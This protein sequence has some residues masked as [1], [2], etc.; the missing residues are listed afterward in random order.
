M[1]DNTLDCRGKY[2]PSVELI[3]WNDVFLIFSIMSNDVIDTTENIYEDA[4][5][6]PP[7][8]SIAP[9]ISIISSAF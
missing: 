7:W 6:R 8:P 5:E 4:V 3:N 2:I 1:P 9:L